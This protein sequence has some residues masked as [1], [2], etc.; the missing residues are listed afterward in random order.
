M[1]TIKVIVNSRYITCPICHSEIDTLTSNNCPH[2]DKIIIRVNKEHVAIFK[3]NGKQCADCRDGEHDNY[4]NNIELVYVRDPD[5][6]KM[7]KRSYMCENH[8]EMYLSDGYE[9]KFC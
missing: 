8:Q 3:E 9:I 6:K 2:L 7:I 1:K 5:T 4:D